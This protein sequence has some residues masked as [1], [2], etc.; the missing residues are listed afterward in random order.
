MNRYLIT[1]GTGF[2]LSPLVDLIL[3]DPDTHSVTL[4]TRGMREVEER[5]KVS[6]LIGNVTDVTFPRVFFTH[7]IHGAA[8]A[9]DLLQPDQA[10]YYYEIVEGSRRIFSFAN[11]MRIR[12]ILH[13]SSGAVSRDTVY[14]RAKGL[15]ELVADHIRAPVKTA[16]VFSVYGEGMPLNGQYAIGR[17][18]WDAINHRK[19][20]YYDTDARRSYIHVK[21]SASWL[22][23]VL[24]RG[25]QGSVFDVGG[26]K[27][28]A[29]SAVATLVAKIAGVPLEKIPATPIGCKDYLPN[30]NRITEELGVKQIIDFE[31]GLR[32]V[33]DYV[34][35]T[36][37]ETPGTPEGFRLFDSGT[38]Q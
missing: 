34:R 21:D 20:R 27:P 26:T 5:N 15:A 11:H 18:V 10:Q 2:L 16:R 6:Y 4:L 29:V 1:G 35:Y 7:L 9:N 23:T 37:V 33:I 17:F 32:N 28:I 30:T 13:V 31:E 3:S 25:R 19:V 36:Y 12:N 14:G 24:N 38:G 8:D 22:Y